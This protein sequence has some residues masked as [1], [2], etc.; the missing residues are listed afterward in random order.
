MIAKAVNRVGVS[1]SWVLLP[2]TGVV[3]VQLLVRLSNWHCVHTCA[4]H[5]VCVWFQIKIL[6]GCLLYWFSTPS[7]LSTPDPN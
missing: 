6:V 4:Y 5:Q 2:Q 1:I 7:L 3:A